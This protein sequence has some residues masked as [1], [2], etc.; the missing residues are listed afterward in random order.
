MRCC[1]LYTSHWCIRISGSFFYSRRKPSNYISIPNGMHMCFIGWRNNCFSSSR[2]RNT[3]NSS[4]S[5][6]FNVRKQHETVNLKMCTHNIQCNLKHISYIA[7]H[8]SL[9]L[10]IITYYDILRPLTSDRTRLEVISS[11]TFMLRSTNQRALHLWCNNK[12]K[13]QKTLF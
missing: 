2:M 3:N 5:I 4:H 9:S 10:I 6:E 1:N 11:W 7:S 13:A 8:L 12:K